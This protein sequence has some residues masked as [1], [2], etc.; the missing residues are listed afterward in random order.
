MDKKSGKN[1]PFIFDLYNHLK[2]L[3]RVQLS[4]Y[5]EKVTSILGIR[6]L[7]LLLL[8][9]FFFSFEIIM[10]MVSQQ[11]KSEI[12][13]RTLQRLVW[14]LTIIKNGQTL[15]VCL[16]IKVQIK[17]TNKSSFQKYFC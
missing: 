11:V 5:T 8:C 12:G 1:K 6:L 13:R 4:T 2:K 16:K 15:T 3:L 14:S 10:N 9:F 17:N 7:F